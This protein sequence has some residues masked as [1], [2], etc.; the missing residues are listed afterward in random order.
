MFIS[1]FRK[2]HFSGHDRLTMPVLMAAGRHDYQVGMKGQYNLAGRL[3]KGRLVEFE[4]SGRFMYVDEP[5]RFA[6]E[7]ADF[8]T[9][10]ATRR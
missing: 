10:S 9:G 5:E 1:G 4:R 2:W 6:R 8:L 3:P 7:V